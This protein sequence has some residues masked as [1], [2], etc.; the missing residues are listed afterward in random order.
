MHVSQAFRLARK[1]FRPAEP[2]K[3]NAAAS[4][5]KPHPAPCSRRS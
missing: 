5:A 3:D 1:T 2:G 4:E